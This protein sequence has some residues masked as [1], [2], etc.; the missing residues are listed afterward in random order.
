[1]KVKE[2]IIMQNAIEINSLS[3]TY[4]DGKQALNNLSFSVKEGEIF[5]L[6]GPNGAGKSTLINILTTYLKPTDGSVMILGENLAKKSEII[7]SQLS[8]VA[9]KNS[10]DGYLTL[11]ENMKFQGR[12]YGVKNKELFNRIEELLTTFKLTQYLDKKVSNCS[13]GVQRRLD[14]AMS[15]MSIPKILFLDEPTTGMDIE[16]RHQM[17]ELI[18]LLNQKYKTTIFLTTHYLEEADK[19]SHTICI[20]KDGHEQ[21]VGTSQELK[22]YLHQNLVRLYFEEMNAIEIKKIIGILKSLTYVK[23][24]RM[25]EDYLTIEVADAK[26]DYNQILSLGI[27]RIL[28]FY[29]AEIVYPTLDDVFLAVANEEVLI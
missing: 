25:L 16:S 14:I 18:T 13:G 15:M 8:C 17:W 21:I 11:Y 6:L 4:K 12:L 3:K 9:Q 7:R 28:P 20:M 10:I 24:I 26:I 19:L 29:R 1:M 5:S 22:N 27:D 23:N 2:V